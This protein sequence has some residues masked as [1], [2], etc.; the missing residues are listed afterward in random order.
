ME[1]TKIN[2]LVTA[3]LTDIENQFKGLLVF[4]D[5]NELYLQ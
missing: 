2:L 4:S 3:E 5:S 1:R